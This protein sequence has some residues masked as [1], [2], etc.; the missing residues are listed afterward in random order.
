MKKTIH[1]LIPTIIVGIITVTLIL[2]NTQNKLDK[3]LED[4]NVQVNTLIKIYKDVIEKNV[5]EI[6]KEA[7]IIL[8]ES[9]LKNI[10]T[11]ENFT[12]ENIIKIKSVERNDK[13][14]E[15]TYT[16]YKSSYSKNFTIITVVSS[17]GEDRRT[18][19]YK[20]YVKDG[21]VEFELKESTRL[22]NRY[23]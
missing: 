10:V 15:I 17:D 6:D 20:F 22:F 5:L 11:G 14:S 2:L 8:D 3:I 9:T 18:V 7:N 21:N 19:K 13:N 4:E 1:I 16:L 23:Y 12:D